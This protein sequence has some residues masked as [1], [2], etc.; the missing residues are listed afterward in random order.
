MQLKTILS[1]WGCLHDST[2][3]LYNEHCQLASMQLYYVIIMY[4]HIHLVLW[5]TTTHLTFLS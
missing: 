2:K 4:K 5:H 1:F 3:I